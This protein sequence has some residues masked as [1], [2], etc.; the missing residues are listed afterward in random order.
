MSE[1]F[2]KFPQISTGAMPAATD[3]LS[4]TEMALSTCK[5]TYTQKRTG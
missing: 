5:H 4:S 3:I 2:Q 1:E